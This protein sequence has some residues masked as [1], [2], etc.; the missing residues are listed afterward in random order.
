MYYLKNQGLTCQYCHDSF[1]LRLG[2]LSFYFLTV[3]SAELDSRLTRR[4]Q[5]V[6]TPSSTV[7]LYHSITIYCIFGDK[8]PHSSWREGSA[9]SP[10]KGTM[11][12]AGVDHWNWFV[13]VLC[14]HSLLFRVSSCSFNIISNT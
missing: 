13:C 11:S 1:D 12:G 3:F 5:H 4:G 7:S 8:F 10:G 9:Q 2:E 6:Q 14:M